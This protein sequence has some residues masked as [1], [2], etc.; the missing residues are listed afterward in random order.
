MIKDL[1]NYKTI[2]GAITFHLDIQQ[3]MKFSMTSLRTWNAFAIRKLVPYIIYSKF[4][5]YQQLITIIRYNT[6]IPLQPW[7][8]DNYT[9][10]NY[11]KEIMQIKTFQI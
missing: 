2:Y 4:Y 1:F 3:Q 11:L 9:I 8:T 6:K 7:I 5:G 10:V